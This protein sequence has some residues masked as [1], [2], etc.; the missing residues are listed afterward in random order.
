MLRRA[1]GVI[2]G[3]KV[4]V[5]LHQ[6]STLSPFLFVIVMDRLT[7]EVRQASQWMMMLADYI[8]ILVR[9][10]IRCKK[11]WRGGCMR[12]KKKE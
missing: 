10:A 5:G 2:D 9:V 11:I 7:D 3:I 12:L 8:V 6:G 1:V 4:E